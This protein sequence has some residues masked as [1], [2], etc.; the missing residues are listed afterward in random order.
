MPETSHEDMRWVDEGPRGLIPW[1]AR[2]LKRYNVEFWTHHALKDMPRE[3][4][5]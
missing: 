4:I 5:H 1:L 3:E 2:Q